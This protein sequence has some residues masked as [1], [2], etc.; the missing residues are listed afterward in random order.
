MK[1]SIFAI[2]L[3]MIIVLAGCDG[4][5]MDSNLKKVTLVLDYTPNTNH[6]GIYLAKELG[7]YKN[8][9]LDVEIIQPSETSTESLVASGKAEFGVS[10]GENVAQFNDENNQI[11]SILGIVAHN[12]SG[13]LSREEKGITRPKDMENKTYCGWGSD[14]EKAIIQSVVKADGGNPDLV[15]IN[16]TAAVDIKAENSPCDVVWAYEGWDKI[17]MEQ[18]NI[19][20]NYIPLTDYHLDWYTPVIISSNDYIKENPDT[21]RAFLD[22]TERGYEKAISSPTLASEKLLKNAPELDRKLVEESQRFLS[23]QYEAEFHFGYQSPEIWEN[24]MNWLK[25][26]NII[27]ND[28]KPEDMYTNEF[29]HGRE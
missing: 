8:A 6:S 25:D 7:Y 14:I 26:E 16:S 20:I 21:V 3:V 10:Y 13:F 18:N 23:T 24:F 9:G 15:K 12:T 4:S 11:K 5:R 19:A 2:V 22:A 27:S 29:G 17:D 28:L 1:K